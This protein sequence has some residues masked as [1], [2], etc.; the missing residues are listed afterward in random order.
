MGSLLLPRDLYR[1]LSH[2][3]YNS[4]D[5]GI[6]CVYA[7][8][9]HMLQQFG[10]THVNGLFRSPVMVSCWINLMAR[11]S[12]LAAASPAAPSNPYNATHA[13]LVGANTVLRF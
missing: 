5:N 9:T 3:N 6:F 10:M 7:E 11:A 2:D 12:K 8:S 1:R 4:I 13:N